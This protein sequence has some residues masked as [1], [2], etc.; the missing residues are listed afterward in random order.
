L[1]PDQAAAIVRRLPV[2][3]ASQGYQSGSVAKSGVQSER[4]QRVCHNEQLT[5]CQNGENTTG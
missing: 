4:L 5:G 1:P 3:G 2:D